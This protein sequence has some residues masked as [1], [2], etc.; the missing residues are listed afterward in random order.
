VDIEAIKSLQF[1]LGAGDKLPP[2]NPVK[3]NS[4]PK[5]A[6]REKISWRTT[7]VDRSCGWGSGKRRNVRK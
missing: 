4:S 2:L 5:S 7:Q 3:V 1:V 6:D